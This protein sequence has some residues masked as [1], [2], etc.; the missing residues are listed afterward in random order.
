LIIPIHKSTGFLLTNRMTVCRKQEVP[1]T[2]GLVVCSVEGP[3]GRAEG[4]LH[5]LVHGV[6]LIIGLQHRCVCVCVCGRGHL[7]SHR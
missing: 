4:T 1:P 6:V 5:L 7:V 2:N 3:E